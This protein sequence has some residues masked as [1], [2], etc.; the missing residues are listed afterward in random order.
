MNMLDYFNW[1]DTLGWHGVH[2]TGLDDSSGAALSNI[3]VATDIR[4]W[5][6][7]RLSY[8]NDYVNI[9]FAGDGFSS[10]DAGYLDLDL[11]FGTASVP[12]PSIIALF[13]AGLFGIGFARRRKA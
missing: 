12:E 2:I 5:D 11:T 8:G 10:I 1:N 6:I 13:A 7:A 9:Q 3:A 4:N